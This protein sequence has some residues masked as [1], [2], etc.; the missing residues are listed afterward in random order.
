MRQKSLTNDRRII[1]DKSKSVDDGRTGFII[2]IILTVFLA[3]SLLSPA[4]LS[5]TLQKADKVVVFKSKR[6][7]ILMREGDILKTY[8]V[9]LGVQPDGHKIKAGDKRTPEGTYVLDSRKW[10]SR[11]HRAIHISYPN[12]SD[13]RNARKFGL[14][15]GR[16]IMIH[17]LPDKLEYV[18]KLHSLA[19]WTDGCIAVTNSEIEEIWHLVPDGTPIE[20]KP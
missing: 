8:K 9:A 4:I 14:S 11:F 3:C 2:H 7:M 10:D 18:G 6:L 19:D 1:R 15:P 5:A 12:E 16:D 17:G 13:I 20:I